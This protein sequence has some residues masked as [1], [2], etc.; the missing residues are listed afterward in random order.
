ML[1]SDR[2]GQVIL[3]KKKI[4]QAKNWEV[5]KASVESGEILTG[6]VIDV[7]QSGLGVT[8]LDN[9]VFV[10]ASLASN[11]FVSDLSSLRGKDVR[12]RIIEADDGG[13]RRKVIGSIKSVLKEEQK[14]QQ[15]EFWASAEVGKTYQGEVKSLT[16]FGAFV[17]IGGVD[18]L[19]HISELSWKKVNHP[20][21]VCK[22]GDT[23]EVFIKSL[24]KENHKISLGYKKD[25]D[26]PWDN[27]IAKYK[28]GDDVEGTV[29]RLVPFGAFVDIGGIDGLIHI[30]E[31]SWK[32][33]AHPSAIF[34]EGQQITAFIKAI[35]EE[36]KKISLGYKRL[37]DNPMDIFKTKY[38]IGD[39]VPCKIARIAAFGAFAEIMDGV[40]GLIHISQIAADRINKVN[41]VLEIGQEVQAKIIDIKD[42]GKISLSLRALIDENT[43]S[44]DDDIPYDQYVVNGDAAPA[45]EI[46]EEVAV[47]EETEAPVEEI[48]EEVAV[49]EK[50]EAPVEEIVEEVAV[51][52]ETE[53]P[54]EEI[55]EEV[56]VVEEAVAPVEEIV[57]EVAVVEETESPVEEIVE[58]VVVEE[59]TEAPAEEATEE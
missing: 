9:R 2:D 15:E 44:E 59:T 52:E 18:G 56:A 21:D 55:V 51:V 13:R 1:V 17:D 28:A 6:K 4:E 12:F 36:N 46:I 27:F 3:S 45:E 58:E 47:V 32:K 43:P 31:M 38:S 26:N 29:E 16:D 40:D 34:E 50:T 19:V 8:C 41:D 37:Q 49:V 14:A 35:D 23:L 33:I 10:P 22:V 53:A 39:V 11:R 30:S 54:V 20:K 48:V 57:E 25:E 42:D 5:I 7:L 24:D